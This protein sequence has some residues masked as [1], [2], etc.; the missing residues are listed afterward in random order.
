MGWAPL[1]IFFL[2]FWN[3]EVTFASPGAN[4]NLSGVLLLLEGA[5]QLAKND[6]QLQNTEIVYLITGSEEAGTRGALE[7]AKKHKEE[8]SDIPTTFLVFDTIADPE[9][10]NKIVTGLRHD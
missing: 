3:Y 6:I 1:S 4:D 2:T 8:F 9:A 7:F 5:K 10:W